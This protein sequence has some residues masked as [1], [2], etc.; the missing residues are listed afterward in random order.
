VDLLAHV[1][2]SAGAPLVVETPA[3]GQAADISLLHE[4]LS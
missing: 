4:L 3:D 1:G 2:R